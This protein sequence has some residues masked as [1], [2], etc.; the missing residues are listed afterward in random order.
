[1]STV[2]DEHNPVGFYIY[3]THLRVISSKIIGANIPCIPQDFPHTLLTFM[4]I[5]CFSPA[6]FRGAGFLGWYYEFENFYLFR[7]RA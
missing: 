6:V 2:K 4:R 5:T 3:A 1:M 7:F